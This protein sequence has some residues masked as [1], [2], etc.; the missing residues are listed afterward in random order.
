M[1]FY[2]GKHLVSAEDFDY[3]TLEEIFKTAEL[4][5]VMTGDRY[6]REGITQILRDETAKPQKAL[7]YTPN[8]PSLRTAIGSLNAV[9]MCG[10]MADT[11]Q[12]LFSPFSKKVANP[13]G[14]KG[15][16]LFSIVRTAVILGYDIIFIR[17]DQI[18]EENTFRNIADL[19]EQIK[20]PISIISMG[21][22]DIEHPLQMLADLATIREAK[23]QELLNGTLNIAFVGDV[24]DSRTFHSLAFGL[25]HY[26][27]NLYLLS[28]PN[29][30]FPEKIWERVASFNQKA[31]LQKGYPRSTLLP[32][33][34]LQEGKGGLKRCC[35]RDPMEVAGEIDVWVFSRFQ[36]NLKDL[37]KKTLAL[38]EKEY[39]LY[40][41]NDALRQTMKKDAIVIHPLP[42]GIE[43]PDELDLDIDPR[44][45]HWRGVEKGLW[46][47][48]GLLKECFN[49][50]YS[51][52]AFWNQVRHKSKAEAFSR[53]K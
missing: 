30:V 21:E 14:P 48:I 37:D 43:F 18:R 35:V 39:Q 49:K 19:C 3:W 29:N 24:E 27:G 51:L 10:G 32:H 15:E 25:A 12:G 40:S 26:G 22:G 33:D 6:G 9:R 17:N 8:D 42:H 11:Y 36:K 13:S 53:V 28:P 1:G 7:I 4:A 20:L 47:K 50:N 41:A 44:F 5:E 45:R 38:R 34:V 46:T 2:L 31:I 16:S 52:L 23:K